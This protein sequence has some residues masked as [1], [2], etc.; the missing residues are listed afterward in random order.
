MLRICD[1]LLFIGSVNDFVFSIIISFCLRNS[2][3]FLYP[4]KYKAKNFQRSL[5]FLFMLQIVQNPP[6][7]FYAIHFP[8]N[9]L[10]GLKTKSFTYKTLL[11]MWISFSC[12]LNPPYTSYLISLQELILSF[13]VDSNI[14]WEKGSSFKN[15][16][17]SNCEV[18]PS[19]KIHHS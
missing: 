9:P 15:A 8:M 5:V 17:K 3:V 18:C 10:K 1:H 6:M 19:S 11:S 16:C 12:F 14:E 4:S 13:P 2:C 7:I